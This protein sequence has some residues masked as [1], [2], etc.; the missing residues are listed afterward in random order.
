MFGE[1]WEYLHSAIAEKDFYAVLADIATILAAAIGGAAIAIT[2]MQVSSG[3]A[4][5]REATAHG[6][7]HDYEVRCFENPRFA[8]PELAKIDFVE[9][10][11]DGEKESFEKYEWFVS[12]MLNAG[13]A[14]LNVRPTSDWKNSVKS[15][16][17]FHHAYLNS[18][19]VRKARHIEQNYGKKFQKLIGRALSEARDDEANDSVTSK[20]SVAPPEPSPEPKGPNIEQTTKT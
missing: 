10:T 19:R 3:R 20:L 15:Q 12:L 8:N 5:Q 14:I 7:F 4:T 16:I 1:V 13:E 2:W 18:D 11:F 6:W 9:G 17:K